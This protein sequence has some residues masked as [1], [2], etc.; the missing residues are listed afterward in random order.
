MLEVDRLKYEQQQHLVIQLAIN[1]EIDR[2]ITNYNIKVD[3][4]GPYDDRLHHP[5]D[6][7][8]LKTQI[9]EYTDR[10]RELHEN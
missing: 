8:K 9:K 10:M 2:I 7:T 1:D 6:L 3:K 4:N 5:E